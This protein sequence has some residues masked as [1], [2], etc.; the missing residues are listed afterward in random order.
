[1]FVLILPVLS[2]QDGAA[3][4]KE[5]C[6]SCHDMPTARVPSLSAIKAM[7]GEAIYLALTSGIMKTRAEGLSTA[8][9]L[10]ADRLHRA[11]R[12]SAGSRSPVYTAPAK[13]MRLSSLPRTRRN[14]TAG[15]PASPT[16]DSRTRP[17]RGSRRRMFRKLKLKW[18]FN[19]G[20]VTMARSQPTIVG[21]RVFIAT[22]TGAVYSLDADTGCT[23]W[24]YQ[25]DRLE[26]DPA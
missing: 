6:A 5:R 9:D 23:H 1:M 22:S 24:G 17:R 11:D 2:A 10:R 14:G 16:R 19:L 13:A 12:R 7:S 18:A 4:Y 8:G 20:D 21:G 26:S 15:A 25:A 3:I